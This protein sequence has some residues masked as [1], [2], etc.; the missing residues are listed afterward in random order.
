MD[1]IIEILLEYSKMKKRLDF[2]AIEKIIAILVSEKGLEEHVRRVKY[3]KLNLCTTLDEAPTLMAYR[4]YSRSIL[5]DASIIMLMYKSVLKWFDDCSP[6][7]QYLAANMMILKSLLHEIDHAEKCMKGLIDNGTFENHLAK[8][9]CYG[10]Y[11]LAQLSKKERNFI[12]NGGFIL[13]VPWIETRLFQDLEN[14]HGYS[15]PLERTADINSALG[16]QNIFNPVKDEFPTIMNFISN[17]LVDFNLRGYGPRRKIMAPTERYLE[18]FRKIPFTG[19]SDYFGER[20]ESLLQAEHKSSLSNRLYL[21][22]KIT[23]DEYKLEK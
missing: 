4:F 6:L 18:D 20:Y 12:L 1:V 13:N 22:L 21:G 3:E 9:C 11:L 2:S 15:S 19:A 23:K 17:M 8:I 16:L 10:D 14:K 5:C 7:E